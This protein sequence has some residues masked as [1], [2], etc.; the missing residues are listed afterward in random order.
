MLPV[1]VYLNTGGI[2]VR[3]S[4][5]VLLGSALIAI[6][7]LASTAFASSSVVGTGVHPSTP[8]EAR[9]IHLYLSHGSP[10]K[11]QIG[12]ITPYSLPGG[13]GLTLAS[14]ANFSDVGPIGIDTNEFTAPNGVIQVQSTAYA[15]APQNT[16]GYYYIALWQDNGL[17]SSN[18][19]VDSGAQFPYGPD[20]YSPETGTVNWTNV[21]TSGNFYLQI[22]SDQAYVTGTSY[23][24]H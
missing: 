20:S 7:S 3:K 22:W 4:V 15:T 12:P 5:A 13:G 16:G 8:G 11:A 23:V 1:E 21:P 14:T 2:Y 17:F 24:Y 18:T 9:T 19:V 6:L 10:D